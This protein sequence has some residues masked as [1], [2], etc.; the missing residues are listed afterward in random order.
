M[1]WFKTVN[2]MSIYNYL[3][4]AYN[5]IFIN[6]DQWN[7]S[8]LLH[9]TSLVEREMREIN[10]RTDIGC[11]WSRNGVENLL[12]I[13]L[14]QKYAPQTWEKYFPNMR[15]NNINTFAMICH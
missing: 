15:S 13:K 1:Y 4:N 14:V 9:V 10:R 2:M 3:Y 8:T 11:R 12:K 5:N 7:D 6:E